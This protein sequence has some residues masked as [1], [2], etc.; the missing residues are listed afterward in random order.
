MRAAVLEP[1][2]AARVLEPAR[3]ELVAFVARALD[4]R[5]D[6]VDVVRVRAHRGVAGGLVERRMR[7]DDARRAARHRLEHRD[8]EALEARRVDERRRAA[9]ESRELVVG[10][11]SRARSRRG[12]RAS[13]PPQ[14]ARADDAQLD[15]EPLRRL[16]SR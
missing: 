12:P 4:R 8:P 13:T 7:R 11:D 15:A 14:P 6:R 1:R 2:E 9:V 5:R 16:R 3:D 10:R